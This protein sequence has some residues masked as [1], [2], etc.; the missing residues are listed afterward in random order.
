MKL[1][2]TV[3]CCDGWHLISM[4]IKIYDS[5]T[6]LCVEMCFYLTI[7]TCKMLLD[8]LHQFVC[9]WLMK[10]NIIC[11]IIALERW[12]YKKKFSWI[13][14]NDKCVGILIKIEISIYFLFS[15]GVGVWENKVWGKKQNWTKLQ[16]PTEVVMSNS[17]HIKI[18][19][20]KNFVMHKSWNH[21]WVWWDSNYLTLNIKN[22]RNKF[23]SSRHYFFLF[24]KLPQ[25]SGI[26]SSTE[27][28]V[29]S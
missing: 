28:F 2:R 20:I 15:N 26:V 24:R 8:T 5:P 29:S 11:D 25:T 10:K 16:S 13:F 27:V 17:F 9:K 1:N 14:W 7:W 6:H 18:N 3:F 19:W 4:L 21:L 12:H 22:T 23:P